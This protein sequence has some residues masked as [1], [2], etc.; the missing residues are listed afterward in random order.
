MI[1]NK[2]FT[3]TEILA[4][5]VIIGIVGIIATGGTIVVS[6]MIKN[7]ML[8]TKKK[9]ILSAAEDY[10]NENKVYI[11]ESCTL[12]NKTYNKCIK[13]K[14]K[15]LIPNYAKTKEKCNEMPC[16]KDDLTGENMNDLELYIY[17]EYDQ[18]YA[19]FAS[20]EQ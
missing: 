18:A 8:E 4:V 20:T 3:L 15:D 1:N 5:I 6:S 13:I 17:Y 11:T 16:F 7:Q 10:G 9:L 19:E 12:N 2:G 14:V